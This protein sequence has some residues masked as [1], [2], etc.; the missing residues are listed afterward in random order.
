MAGSPRIK[1]DSYQQWLTHRDTQRLLA[2][3]AGWLREW[4]ANLHGHHLLYAGI[5]NQPRFLARS[6]LQ[7][8]FSMSLDWQEGVVAGDGRMSESAWPFAD[9]SLDVVVLQHCLDMSSRPHQ[10]IR[11]AA[12]SV[13]PN[14]Y[15]IITGFNPYSLWGTVRWARTFSTRLPW[16]TNPVSERRLR[17]WL[18]LLDFRTEQS[19]PIAHTW[20]LTLGSERVSR[21]AD[22]VLAGAHWLPASG[23]L[24]IARKTIAGMTPIRPRRWQIKDTAFGLAQ[25][26]ASR[27]KTPENLHVG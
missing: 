11:E 12:R 24:L 18:T 9:D 26:V 5:D 21:R 23:Y 19:C 27:D 10:I 22:R 2:L 13:L 3:E 6:R 20:P 4:V 8:T 1:P 16:I 17:D 14:G 15:L 25:P 7:H